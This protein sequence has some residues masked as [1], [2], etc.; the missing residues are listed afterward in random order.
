MQLKK[1]QG[2]ND[3]NRSL[4]FTSNQVFYFSFG[5]LTRNVGMYL[6]LKNL[7]TFSKVKKAETII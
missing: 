4:D 5:F 3:C 1:R 6:H 2:G 7:D